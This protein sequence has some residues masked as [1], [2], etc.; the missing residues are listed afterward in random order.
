M[1]PKSD[2]QKTGRHMIRNFTAQNGKILKFWGRH[3]V[4]RKKLH[5]FPG[6]QRNR[7]NISVNVNWG[8]VNEN[9]CLWGA[10]LHPRGVA[11]GG[12]NFFKMSLH[13]RL[14]VTKSFKM[15]PNTSQ[16]DKAFKSYIKK[17]ED[18]EEE[19][20][21]DDDHFFLGFSYCVCRGRQAAFALRCCA[22]RPGAP[23]PA[24]IQVIRCA[25]YGRNGFLI[26]R[27]FL[28]LVSGFHIFKF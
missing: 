1:K 2:R 7:L 25:A 20:D 8:S 6:N 9:R 12:W 24:T 16:S 14:R 11:S 3:L 27:P 4:E 18:E 10:Q 17:E 23:A 13:R 5:I 15:S 26:L 21:E 22:N 28:R 19:E